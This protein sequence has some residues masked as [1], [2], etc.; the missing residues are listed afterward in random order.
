MKIKIKANS[1]K[2]VVNTVSGST[3]NGLDLSAFPEGASFVGN[4]ETHNA[5]I[6]NVERN[7]GELQV[8]IG[9]CGLAYECSSMSGSYDWRGSEELIDAADYDP[10]KCYIRAAS[11]PEG[12]EYVKRD[13]GWTVV[14][15]A[16]EEAE[17]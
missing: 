11:A 4:E 3:V 13:N 7:N 6:F 14:V 12:A 9:Q 8:T 2:D 16:E 17:Q 5:G 15:P 10:D 1:R